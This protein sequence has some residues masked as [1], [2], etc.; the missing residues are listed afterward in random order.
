MIY[1]S[2]KELTK[3][4][5]NIIMS[6]DDIL[7]IIHGHQLLT[8][9]ED[10]IN[11][12]LRELSDHVRTTA[13]HEYTEIS[14]DMWG[15]DDP[16][17]SFPLLELSS[18]VEKTAKKLDKQF[19]V[20]LTGYASIFIYPCSTLTLA[21]RNIDLVSLVVESQVPL[22]LGDLEDQKVPLYNATCTA[23]PP[24]TSIDSVFNLYRRV[25]SLL[26]LHAAFCPE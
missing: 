3:L 7:Q 13:V 2:I 22:Y 9:Y 11:N 16:D 6:F 26:K 24:T 5:P 21:T 10:E 17:I 1:H 18:K 15:L 12:R 23:N 14:N 20:P 19:G 8:R 25:G 4:N